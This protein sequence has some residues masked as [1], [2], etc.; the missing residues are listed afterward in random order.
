[1]PELPEVQTIVYDLEH[2][3][4][5]D[6]RISA[7]NVFWNKS[8]ATPTPAEFRRQIKGQRISAVTR[9]GKFIILHLQ[10]P[11]HLLIH[12]RMTGSIEFLNRRVKRSKHARVVLRL[13]DGRR[14][15]FRDPRK[16]GRLYLVPD[17]LII[18][19]NLGIEPLSNHFTSA[20][21]ENVLH[22]VSRMLKPLLLDQGFIAGLG[23]IYVDEALWEA[24]LHP[25]RKS[26]SLSTKE[27]KALHRSIRKVLRRGLLSKGTTLGGASSETTFRSLDK[28]GGQNKKFLKVFRRT[29]QPCPRCATNI[30]RLLVG[31][32]GTHICPGCQTL[33]RH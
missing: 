9:R 23:N 26:D 6:R 4:L 15:C 29:A 21:F 8:I 5:V 7:A 30:E 10:T 31:Q 33:S 16:F 3:A 18:T 32:R 17:P 11:W 19:G 28:R 2:S 20:W 25:R 13:D 1:M 27:V 12:L 22:K 24:R 14:F